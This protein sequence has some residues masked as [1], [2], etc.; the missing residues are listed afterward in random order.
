MFCAPGGEPRYC[1]RRQR[2]GQPQAA[3]VTDVADVTDAADV[4]DVADVADVADVTD[5]TDVAD[6]AD[7]RDRTAWTHEAR[8][9]SRR[10]Q[11]RLRHRT[12]SGVIGA[13]L[14]APRIPTDG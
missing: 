5:V 7:R 10:A 9:G 12:E 1:L 3:D 11:R 8:S 4:T 14:A 2:K 6:V 13:R